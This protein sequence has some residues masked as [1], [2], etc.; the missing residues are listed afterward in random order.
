MTTRGVHKTE[1]GTITTRVTS[2]FKNNILMRQEF[3]A[4]V[5][6]SVIGV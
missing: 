3:M 1:C 4:L 6:S 2:E 5:T